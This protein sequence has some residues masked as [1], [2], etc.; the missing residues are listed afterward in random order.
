MLYWGGLLN[1]YLKEFIVTREINRPVR[2]GW[3]QKGSQQ[4]IFCSALTGKILLDERFEFVSSRI[5]AAVVRE[6]MRELWNA[7]IIKL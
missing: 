3:I 6:V 5:V 4:D 2:E 7:K 1:N